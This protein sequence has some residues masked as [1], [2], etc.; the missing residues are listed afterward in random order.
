MPATGPFRRSRTGRPATGEGLWKCGPAAAA[1]TALACAAPAQA[2]R[3][4]EGTAR[5]AVAPAP[6]AA[7]H[8]PEAD[9]ATALA[10]AREHPSST[11]AP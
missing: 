8:D 5:V 10:A 11:C 9:L 7:H 4:D 2:G 1:L 6:A 3:L